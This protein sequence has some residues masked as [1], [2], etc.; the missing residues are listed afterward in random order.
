MDVTELEPVWAAH[1]AP[2]DPPQL[3]PERWGIRH[4]PT[5]RWLAFGPEARCRSLV[6]RLTAAPAAPV[7]PG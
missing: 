2:P 4:G 6:A 1:P 5:G 3:G 7:P